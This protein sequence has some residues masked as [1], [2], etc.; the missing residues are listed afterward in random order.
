[1]Y[2]LCR[3][4]LALVLLLHVNRYKGNLDREVAHC[5]DALARDTVE[6]GSNDDQEQ[7]A[8]LRALLRVPYAGAKSCLG[9]GVNRR[10]G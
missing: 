3:D 6:A 10:R 9:D 2:G 4:I 7:L 1:M 5:V 8:Q